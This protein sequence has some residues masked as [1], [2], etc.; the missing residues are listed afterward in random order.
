MHC[1]AMSWGCEQDLAHDLVQETFLI[2][3]N[4]YDQLRDSSALENWL[5]TILANCHKTYI[6]K[7]H[8]TCSL[9]D[10]DELRS[11]DLPDQ[12]LEQQNISAR[13]QHAICRLNDDH[14]KVLTLVDM[15]GMSYIEVAQVLDIRIGTVMSRLSRARN[16]MKSYLRDS[17]LLVGETATSSKPVRRIK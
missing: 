2:A 12:L 13:V 8:K 14:R 5:I 11:K 7:E 1:I 17:L 9:E 15:E 10:H 16:R 6:R 3:L 4:K